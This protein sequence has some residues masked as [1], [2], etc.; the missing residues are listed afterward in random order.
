[1]PQST[2]KT[3]TVT[4]RDVAR[5]CR[6]SPTTVSMVLN[7]TASASYI[8]ESTKK[9]ITQVAEGMGYQPNPF[10]QAL[11]SQHSHTIGVMV[12]DIADPYCAQILR[13]IE[14]SFLRSSYL[15]FLV[16]IQN[17]R[18]RFK[19]YLNVLLGRR[20]EG[21]II[22]ANSLSF[23][24][25]LLSASESRKIPSVI[26]GR[27]PETDALSW[28]AT[29]NQAG[30]QQALEH[31][32]RLG[33]R[34]IAFIRGSSMIVDSH[35]QWAGICSFA[36]AA[37]LELDPR[38]V[39][40]LSDPFSSYEAGFECT[41]Q[42]LAFE[43]PFTALV[44]FDDMTA[45]GAIRA[46]ISAGL[47]VPLDCSVIGFDD[48]PAAAFYNPALTSV[49]EHMETLASMGAEILIEAIRAHRKNTTV[50][51]VHHKVKPEL[52]VRESTAAPRDLADHAFPHNRRA[53]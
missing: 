25:E 20:V 14:N 33:H 23:E 50:S 7:H 36:A 37:G 17:D 26:L 31:L 9:R 21:L 3:T 28:V 34:K 46:L 32:Y 22:L 18:L 40:T 52:I 30:T 43:L 5:E 44:A 38:L 11:R 27:E 8:P 42:L 47:R 35:H 13:G 1:V 16:D 29:D 24:T 51:P 53:G 39:V 19:K 41:K 2:S 49:R 12:P 6:L 48:I 45:F 15:P 4:I 10:A